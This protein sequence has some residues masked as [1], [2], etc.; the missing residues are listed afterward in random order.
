MSKLIQILPKIWGVKVPM[1]ADDFRFS[2]HNNVHLTYV[3]KNRESIDLGSKNDFNILG[4]VT[5]SEISFDASDVVE[6]LS[7]G[8]EVPTYKFHENREGKNAIC[9]NS[10]QSFRSA[11]PEDIIWENPF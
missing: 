2:L 1:D 7:D 8:D 9:F 11:L 4:T 3:L 6:N 5:K 10:E